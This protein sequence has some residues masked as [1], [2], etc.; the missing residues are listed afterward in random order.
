VIKTR[1]RAIL[2]TTN[3]KETV[4]WLRETENKIAFTETFSEQSHIRERAYNLVVPRIPTTYDLKDSNHLQELEETNGLGINT[5]GKARWI[6]PIERRKPNQTHAFA[7]FTLYKADMANILIRD[8]FLI[9]G[10]KVWPKKQKQEPIQ[11][12][13]CRRWGHFVAECKSEK[14]VC[15]NCGKG[16]RTSACSNKGKVYCAVCQDHMHTSWSRECPEFIRRC[17]I[18]DERNPKNTMPYFPTESDWSLA[19]RPGRIPSEDRFLVRFAVNNLTNA[20]KKHPGLTPRL[21]KRMQKHDM[22]G[23]NAANPNLI[24]L[25]QGK[26]K[27]IIQANAEPQYNFDCDTAFKGDNTDEQNC[28]TITGWD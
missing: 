5:I 13:K 17:I 7:I 16:H 21:Q 24:P 2:L 25:P 19:V 1:K 26:G 15:G 22:V 8:G 3:S 9:S 11:C 4:T 28:F 10:T 12:L 18:L 23:T 20:N 27:G 14:E 6:K